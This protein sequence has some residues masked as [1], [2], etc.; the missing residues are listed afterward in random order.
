MAPTPPSN[1]LPYFQEAAN[2]TGMPISVVEAQNY[3]ESGYGSNVG[4]SSAGAEGPWQF[5]PSTWNSL[6]FPPGQENDWATS[7]HAYETYMKQLL[8]QEGGNISLAL[9]AYNAGP[10]NVGLGAGYASTILSNAGVSGGATA[11]PGTAVGS[12]G[13]P[14]TQT[15]S[16]T[17]SILGGLLGPIFGPLL[18]QSSPVSGAAQ[19]G[20]GSFLGEYTLFDWFLKQFGITNVKDFFIRLG[21]I[22]MGAVLIIVGLHSI[23]GMS[24]SDMTP[25]PD[26]EE[27]SEDS[28][29]KEV[30]KPAKASKPKSEPA[31]KPSS[32]GKASTGAAGLKMGTGAGSATKTAGADLGDVAAVAA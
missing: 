19:A 2:A 17:S 18:G 27:K 16:L 10:G 1:L 5:L 12:G 30:S 9:A 32:P 11:G 21:L 23:T 8:A 20:L 22:L 15:T 4:P 26:I 13:L 28:A 6:G 14:S 31:S 7:T 3:E 29:E 25:Q 24:Y